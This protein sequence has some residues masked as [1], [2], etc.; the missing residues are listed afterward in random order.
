MTQLLAAGYRTNV[1]RHSAVNMRSKDVVFQSYNCKRIV[2]A[3]KIQKLRSFP[4][5]FIL[6][7]K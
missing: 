6:N 1:C 2:N 3:N 4:N 7:L 5:N